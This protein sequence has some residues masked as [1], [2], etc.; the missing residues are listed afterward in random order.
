LPSRNL[1]IVW[2]A[3]LDLDPINICDDQQIAWLEALVWPDEPGRVKH[4]RAAL[5]IARRK[6]PRVVK[7][8]LR[9]DV[10]A[11]ASDA[12]SDATLVIFHSATLCYVTDLSDRLAFARLVRELG[13]TWI[14]NEGPTVLPAVSDSPPQPGPADLLLARNGKPQAWADAHGTAIHW[15]ADRFGHRTD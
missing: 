1:D 5:G 14:S 15:L 11:L 3:G 12:P 9:I 8:D 4:L 2:R 10:A 6:P 13:A 7:G